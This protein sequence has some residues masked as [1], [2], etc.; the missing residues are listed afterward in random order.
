MGRT[1]AWLSGFPWLRISTTLVTS[2]GSGGGV[3]GT[4]EWPIHGRIRHPGRDDNSVWSGEGPAVL[5]L[6]K[7]NCRV[8]RPV[9]AG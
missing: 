7:R 6:I 5:L 8:P 3:V 9:Q 2:W 4:A 1:T